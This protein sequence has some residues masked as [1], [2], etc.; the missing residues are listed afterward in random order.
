L[1]WFEPIEIPKHFPRTPLHPF[2]KEIPML[3]QILTQQPH[4][5]GAILKG[6][7]VW[8]WGLLAALLALGASQ[9]PDRKLSLP[10]V[11]MVPIAMLGFALFGM[12]S[13]F[14]NSGQLAPA[15]LA[16]LASATVTTGLL[17]W[18]P[19]PAGAAFDVSTARF[20]VPGSVVPLLIIL[21]I[22]LTKYGVGVEMAI[23]PNAARNAQFV[24]SVAVLY[25]AFNGIFLARSLRLLRLMW[26][27][28]TAAGLV[29]VAQGA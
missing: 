17:L 27:K 12:V 10:R 14:G 16:W 18:L 22:F 3:I 6:T 15:A 4:M 2:F 9:L 1:A 13:A 11:T 23:N 19:A 21:G 28:R 20:S 8:V 25:G 24:V 29:S 7:P 5:L 26:H